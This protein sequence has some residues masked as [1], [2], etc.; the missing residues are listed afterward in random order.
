MFHS[1]KP[2]SSCLRMVCTKANLAK[3]PHK[4][5]WTFTEAISLGW[6]STCRSERSDWAPSLANWLSWILSIRRRGFPFKMLEQTKF[7]GC[8]G[9]NEE[10]KGLKH[11]NLTTAK[12]MH[13]NRVTLFGSSIKS[14]PSTQLHRFQKWI[15]WRPFSTT[16]S[17]LIL[18]ARK[19]SLVLLFT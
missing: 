3:W 11:A 15:N 13:H 16:R 19:T 1:R 12:T 5:I 4:S 7:D 14:Y 8:L 10:L 9:E 18:M 2:N 17:M 6:G